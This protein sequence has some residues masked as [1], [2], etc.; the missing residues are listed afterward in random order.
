MICFVFFLFL[1]ICFLLPSVYRF[2]RSGRL[3]RLRLNI[4]SKISNELQQSGNTTDFNVPV[5]SGMSDIFSMHSEHLTDGG[6]SV[7]DQNMADL[8]D[9]NEGND[10]NGA[11]SND[12]WNFNQL[13]AGLPLKD[14][15]SSELYDD[16]RF[17]PLR[18][19]S[20]ID[21]EVAAL[22]TASTSNDFG[23]PHRNNHLYGMLRHTESPNLNLSQ[24][25]EWSD[26]FSNSTKTEKDNET[27]TETSPNEQNTTENFKNVRVKLESEGDDDDRAS[28]DD[29]KNSTSGFSSNVELTEEVKF[30]IILFVLFCFACFGFFVLI[31]TTFVQIS[32]QRLESVQSVLKQTTTMTAINAFALI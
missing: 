17:D 8:N 13:Y 25:I 7:F 28:S 4:K 30:S 29:C 27:T 24:V 19:F 9:Y 23:S 16:N 12:S 26:Y 32:I 5:A 3:L 14:E 18:P 15:P 21:A 1:Y 2:I 20:D 31:S 10:R 6:V 11:R 22:S